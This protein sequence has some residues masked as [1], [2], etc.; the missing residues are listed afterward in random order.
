MKMLRKLERKDRKKRER[1][2]DQDEEE[3][4]MVSERNEEGKKVNGYDVNEE[5][6]EVE[7]EDEG[8][9]GWMN[10]GELDQKLVGEGTNEEV[11]YMVNKLDMFEFGTLEEAMERGGTRPTTTK[12][13]RGWK[14]DDKGGRFVRCRL[15]ARDF[16]VGM[17]AQGMICLRRCHRCRRRKL[18]L[19]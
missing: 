9:G 4:G 17:K 11:N 8:E 18:C 6:L 15:V 10:E 19:G 2:G 5:I 7:R 14:D 16:K 1:E 12:W 13:V 3:M